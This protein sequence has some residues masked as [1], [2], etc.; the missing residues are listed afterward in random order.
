MKRRLGAGLLFTAAVLGT[1]G[2][3]SAHMHYITFDQTAVL[4]DNGAIITGVIE[5]HRGWNYQVRVKLE[6]AQGY[7]PQGRT[8]GRPVCTA[9]PQLFEIR[10]QGEFAEGPAEISVAAHGGTPSQGILHSIT[11]TG[12]V[13]LTDNG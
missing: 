9:T 1:P 13:E 2:P 8:Q 10:I 4:D 11:S 12:F 6:N 7:Y 5:C 3:A